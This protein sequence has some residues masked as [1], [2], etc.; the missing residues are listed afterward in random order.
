MSNR[1]LVNFARSASTTL[2]NF[3]SEDFVVQSLNYGPSLHW[4]VQ[5]RDEQVPGK[6]ENP[7]AG[8]FEE[9]LLVPD[10]TLVHCVHCMQEDFEGKHTLNDY[11]GAILIRDPREVVVS[12][13]FS[14]K[15][16]HGVHEHRKTVLS[17]DKIEGMKFVIDKLR[18]DRQIECMHSW[19]CAELD[20]RWKLYRYEDL[21]KSNET[22]IPGLRSILDH[23]D[24]KCDPGQLNKLL[25]KYSY[26]KLSS[27][28]KRGD[29]DKQSHHRDCLPDTWKKEMPAEVLE[30]LYSIYGT[31]LEEMG[32]KDD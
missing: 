31:E 24:T 4:A 30:Y 11:K 25:A 19:C 5:I 22:Q 29:M 3:F 9:D 26:E 1:I 18:E 20:D 15:F 21:F 27:N 23:F 28:R 12:S 17:L 16:S 10:N 7:Y 8:P 13:Y 32:Y 6:Y 14:W 2:R